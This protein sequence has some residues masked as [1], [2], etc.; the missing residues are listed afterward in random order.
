MTLHRIDTGN[1]GASDFVDTMPIAP[2]K[3]HR[4]AGY[5]GALMEGA[6]IALLVCLVLAVVGALGFAHL[7]ARLLA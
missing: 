2:R 5:D 1:L 7:I 6:T 4:E 3:P